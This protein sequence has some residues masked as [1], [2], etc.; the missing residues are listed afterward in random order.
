MEEYFDHFL[1][2]LD[3]QNAQILRL[4]VYRMRVVLQYEWSRTSWPGT[5]LQYFAILIGYM[6]IIS[7][8]IQDYFA[9]QYNLYILN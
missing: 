5:T 7:R 2:I 1:S 8:W 6:H 9:I 3:A 4:V